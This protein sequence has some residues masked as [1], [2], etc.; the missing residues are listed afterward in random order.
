MRLLV[1][2][3]YR[4]HLTQENRMARQIRSVLLVLGCAVASNAYADSHDSSNNGINYSYAEIR[5]VDVDG[6]DGIEFGGSYRINREFYGVAS[7]QDL[8]VNRGGDLEILEFGG[9]Y[10]RPYENIDLAIEFTL[11][12]ADFSGDSESGF[13][14][15]GGARGFFSPELEW[16]GY[17]KHV[18]IEESDTFLELGGDYHFNE[19]L[20]AG[21]TIELGSDLD[22][23]TIGGR[24][25]F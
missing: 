23:L 4:H 13:S 9:G 1:N 6:G 10:I 24:F 2:K 22:T 8:D 19:S 15:A 12:D 11:I 17:A 25:H 5:F 20:S 18:D 14:L 16:R 3:D 7:F 21:V